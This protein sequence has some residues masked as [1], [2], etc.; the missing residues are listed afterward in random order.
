MRSMQ[1]TR[2]HESSNTVHQAI[3]ERLLGEHAEKQHPRGRP[4]RKAASL[5][6]QQQEQGRHGRDEHGDDE[7]H[8]SPTRIGHGRQERRQHEPAQ[9]EVQDF[10]CDARPN[11]HMEQA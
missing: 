3:P 9:T 4:W 1:P 7:R 6:A 11:L 10:V 5:A 2:R 8:R